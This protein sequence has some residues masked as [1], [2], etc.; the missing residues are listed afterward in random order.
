MSDDTALAELV[1]ENEGGRVL[2]LVA[3]APGS[4]RTAGVRVGRI[5]DPVG[6]HDGTRVLVDR[7][8]PRGMTR[9]RARI[10]EWCKAAAR[11]P[12][13]VRGITTTRSASR[14]SA[15]AIG[16]SSTPASK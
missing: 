6:E 15:A 8:W 9:S 5:Y 3:G 7:L 14:S 16:T 10:D 13:F 2:R 12:H 1:W 11:R 4:P